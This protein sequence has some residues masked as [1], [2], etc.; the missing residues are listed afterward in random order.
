MPTPARPFSAS[1]TPCTIPG[2]EAAASPVYSTIYCAIAGILILLLSG[3]HFAPSPGTVFF[4]VLNGVVLF[5]YL[6]SLLFASQRGPFALNSVAQRFGGIVVCLLVSVT[7]WGDRLSTAQI[8]GIL[9]MLAAL[10]VLNSGGI[11][12]R[13]VK[14][15]YFFWV[16]MVFLANGLYGAILDAQQRLYP[17]QRNEAVILAFLSCSVISLIYLIVTQRSRTAVC[18]RMGKQAWHCTLAGGIC[19]GFASL[20]L[21]F[22]LGYLPSYIL[23]TIYNG[24]VLVLLVFLCRIVLKEAITRMTILGIAMSVASILLLSL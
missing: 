13:G 8:V 15:G 24:G 20:T 7:Y 12:F 3:L 21:V 23:Y 22:L 2:P 11:D 16:A 10:L 17:G 1:S 6:L 9:L 5:F 18:F 19:A 4:G 14:K